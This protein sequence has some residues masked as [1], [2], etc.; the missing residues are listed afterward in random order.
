[1]TELTVPPEGFDFHDYR[2]GLKLLK[3]D[4]ETTHLENRDGFACPACGR[5][6]DRLLV[7][8][9]RENTFNSPPGPFCVVHTD[10]QIVLLT[11]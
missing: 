11:H 10:H 8:E 5:E 4:R 7:S 1:M 9:K 6:F 3:D 2:S